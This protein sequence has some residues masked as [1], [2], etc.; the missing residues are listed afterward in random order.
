[1]KQGLVELFYKEVTGSAATDKRVG[2]LTEVAPILTEFPDDP[3][4][5]P[6]SGAV[7]LSIACGKNYYESM[8]AAI[9]M[10]GDNHFVFGNVIKYLESPSSWF[11][12]TPGIGHPVY[13]SVDPRA[14]KIKEIGDKYFSTCYGLRVIESEAERLGVCVNMAGALAPYLR[15]AGFE[16]HN[17]D[18]FPL[19]CRMIGL[20]KIYNN[21]KEG[22]GIKLQSSSNIFKEASKLCSK[23]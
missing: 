7:S 20:S 11:G 19:M 6:S 2:F 3:L 16:K 22:G 9:G 8:A 18:S 14:K 23:S 15:V 10:F 5:P 1:M 4:E 21:I 17:A 13:K 12:D